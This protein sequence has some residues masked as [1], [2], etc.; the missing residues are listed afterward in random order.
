MSFGRRADSVSIVSGLECPA[1]KL[2]CL[3]Q[4]EKPLSVDP[5]WSPGTGWR[6]HRV[7]T[8]MRSRGSSVKLQQGVL[9][10]IERELVDTEASCSISCH[11]PLAAHSWDT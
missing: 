2:Q 5:A 11:W 9:G 8:E 6:S 1:N 10:Q 3:L 4:T 7:S